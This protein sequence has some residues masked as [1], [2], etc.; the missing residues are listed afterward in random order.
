[1]KNIKLCIGVGI[2]LML[3]LLVALHVISFIV[4][5]DSLNRRISVRLNEGD[6]DIY[7]KIP[8]GTYVVKFTDEPYLYPGSGSEKYT[9][10]MI[11]CTLS[12]DNIDIWSINNKRSWVFYVPQENEFSS[13]HFKVK[14]AQ[15]TAS[16]TFLNFGSTK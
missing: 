7:V 2:F 1:M 13:L 8:S 16:D 14:V 11:S 15:G 5:M 4:S 9:E 3:A 10:A 12:I 6:N